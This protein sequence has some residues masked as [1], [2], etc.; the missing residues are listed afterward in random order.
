MMGVLSSKSFLVNE[1]VYIDVWFGPV[2][3]DMEVVR[4]GLVRCQLFCDFF[5]SFFLSLSVLI[6]LGNLETRCGVD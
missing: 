6:V 4:L 5:V 2:M 1:I 3:G